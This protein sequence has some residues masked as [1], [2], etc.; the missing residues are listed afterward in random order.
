MINAV[1]PIMD[2]RHSLRL[3]IKMCVIPAV[4]QGQADLTTLCTVTVSSSCYPRISEELP[5]N[6]AEMEALATLGRD[7]MV[8]GGGEEYEVGC[9]P[10]IPVCSQWWLL[11]LDSWCGWYSI[12]LEWN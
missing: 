1:I 12:P 8:A 9:I 6:Y 7:V 10:C 3:K 5:D 2:L 4:C 11:G